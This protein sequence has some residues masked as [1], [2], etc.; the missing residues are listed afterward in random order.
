MA[1]EKGRPPSEGP[2]IQNKKATV[3][4]EILERVEAG[5]ALKGSEVKSLREGKATLT[6]A[7]ARIEGGQV[8]LVNFQVEP[9]GKASHFNHN[10]KRI[11]RLLLHKREIK[12]LVSRVTIKG[13]TLI[14]LRVYFNEKGLVKV[15]LALARGRQVHDK[16]QV[17]RKRQDLRDM[18]R[19]AK[20]R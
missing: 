1:K 19:A 2:R 9:Y 13:Q 14:P 12:K 11:K 18:A 8:A 15:E 17:E 3:N 4:Y 10:P 7:Y 5:I 6:D 20:R 16:R